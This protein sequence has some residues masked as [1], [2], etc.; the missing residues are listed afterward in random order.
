MSLRDPLFVISYS[1]FVSVSVSVSVSLPAPLRSGGV[2]VGVYR[3]RPSF[4]I[5]RCPTAQARI[6]QLLTW[7]LCAPL[8]NMF[9]ACI[10]PFFDRSSVRPPTLR[11]IRYFISAMC[12]EV[13]AGRIRLVSSAVDRLPVQ[14]FE[15]AA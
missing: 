2:A 11:L 1:V 14:Q 6:W 7:V 9:G 8:L 5:G 10:S 12:P 15:R 4:C 13:L 3:A